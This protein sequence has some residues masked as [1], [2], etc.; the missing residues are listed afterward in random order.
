[1]KNKEIIS[2]ADVN[3]KVAQDKPIIF[4]DTCA[5]VDITRTARPDRKIF[6][7]KFFSNY[8]EIADWINRGLVTSISSAVVSTEYDHHFQNQLSES[9]NQVD[10]L[11][12]KILDLS[13]FMWSADFSRSVQATLD[14]IDIP[15]VIK[16]C[17]ETI[18]DKTYLIAEQQDFNDNAHYRTMNG[19][20]P[21]GGKES[22]KDSYIWVTF[23]SLVHELHSTEKII[24]FTSNTSDFVVNP[25]SPKSTQLITDLANI[26]KDAVLLTDVAKVNGELHRALKAKGQI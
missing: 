23:L 17:T 25:D 8:K 24:F 12:G 18:C 4:W 22:Y 19:I 14:G 20:S 13:H 3:T 15:T 2:L 5:L 21:S 1:M 26:G 6:G 10:K 16:E 7:F 9:S 11:K